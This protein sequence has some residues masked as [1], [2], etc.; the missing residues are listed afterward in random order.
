M[1]VDYAYLYDILDV[2]DVYYII[3]TDIYI[4]MSIHAHDK[5]Q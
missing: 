2:I 1:Q 3:Y 5:D 4:Y